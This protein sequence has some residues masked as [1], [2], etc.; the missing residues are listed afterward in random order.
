[1]VISNRRIQQAS[2][3]FGIPRGQYT[4]GM[5]TVRG[6]QRI[7]STDPAVPVLLQ[8]P[9][10]AGRQILFQDPACTIPVE[11]P[12]DPIGGVRHP[13]T[14]E[15]IAVQ[16]TDAN[17]PVYGGIE[18]GAVS[19]SSNDFLVTPSDQGYELNKNL[20]FMVEASNS[21]AASGG[22]HIADLWSGSGRVVFRYSDDDVFY[23]NTDGN[24]PA[25]QPALDY[26]D[27]EFAHYA[28][29]YDG[30][31][32]KTYRDGVEQ[33]DQQVDF[34]DFGTGYRLTIG[35]GDD[36][37]SSGWRGRVKWCAFWLDVFD[38]AG[39]EALT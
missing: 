23:R 11:S 27:E 31:R 18:V 6:Y 8:L 7:L 1:M 19:N 36:P 14:G 17:R 22:Q 32:G 24:T 34:G 30:S 21:T 16:E 33:D 12:G 28:T 38:Q 20:T 3:R 29:V 4:A 37:P 35:A 25:Q 13:L 2:S 5:R 26:L 10:W 39:I 9:K 15:I